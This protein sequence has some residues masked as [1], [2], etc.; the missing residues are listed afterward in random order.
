MGRA[1]DAFVIQGIRHNIPFLTA[2]MRH[3][4]WRAGDL[5]TGFIAEEYPDGFKPPRLGDEEREE[6]MALAVAIDHMSNERRRMISHQMAGPRV[7]FAAR[8]VVMLGDERGEADVS[9]PID[10]PIAVILKRQGGKRRKLS[11]ESGWW[12]GEPLWQGRIGGRA[13]SVQ[14]QPIANGITLC[15]GGATLE[16]R[17][18]TAREA[19]LA[20]LM[21]GKHVGDSGKVLRCPMPGL[22]VSVAVS[23]GQEVKAGEPL[24]VV[25]AM[26]MENILRAD[27]DAT[28]SKVH[29]KAGDSL[30]VDAVILEVA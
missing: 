16:A 29:A 4:R 9:G 13:L 22:V 30:P 26:K 21:P 10:G 19:E 14:V 24:A 2:L 28:V 5:S 12:F 7:A 15:R 6:L 18:Y 27:R 1:L 23:P 20:A 25:E 17:V 11:V 8:R 3:P